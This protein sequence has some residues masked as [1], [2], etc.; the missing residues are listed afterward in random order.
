MGALTGA[1]G[2]IARSLAIALVERGHAVTGV[3]RAPDLAKRLPRGLTLV[4]GDPAELGVDDR[5]DR[6]A[7]EGA[8]LWGAGK[9]DAV[10]AF[11]EA[12]RRFSIAILTCHY[13]W[14]VTSSRE[15]SRS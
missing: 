7:V 15:T 3:S 8:P 12:R 9:A 6:A 14:F 4:A 13:A 2:L 11:A 5:E 10:R 1:T